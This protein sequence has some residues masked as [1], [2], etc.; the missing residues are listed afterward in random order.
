M[1]IKIEELEEQVCVVYIKF[2]GCIDDALLLEF[3]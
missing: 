2:I 3:L 1:E